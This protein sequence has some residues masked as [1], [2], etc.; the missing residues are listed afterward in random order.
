MPASLSK[1]WFYQ[2]DGDENEIESPYKAHQT[3]NRCIPQELSYG[4]GRGSSSVT[5]STP[6]FREFSFGTRVNRRH[7]T[8]QE[9]PRPD[10]D[11]TTD[12]DN[13]QRRT[14]S[15]VN[16]EKQKINKTKQK[17]KSTRNRNDYKHNGYVLSSTDSSFNDQSNWILKRDDEVPQQSLDNQASSTLK[18]HGKEIF[19]SSST[20]AN[21]GAAEIESDF[22][23][24]EV[25]E[26]NNN[27]T[28]ISSSSY[29]LSSHR[30]NEHKVADKTYNTSS[31]SIENHHANEISKSD[32]PN[33]EK[34]KVVTSYGR[35]HSNREDQS[36]TQEQRYKVQVS[37]S[38][39]SGKHLSIAGDKQKYRIEPVSPSMTVQSVTVHTASTS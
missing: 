22:S 21:Q 34:S 2:P 18:S 14:K 33:S 19:P 39:K 5:S 13:F 17:P 26:E 29:M 8:V 3:E 12:E 38:R 11:Y 9:R 1:L 6:E 36:K 10:R 25:P 16:I 28:K 30:N 32:H 37:A 23:W 24:P 20:R 15:E 35:Y 27:E 4:G 31:H 7:Y